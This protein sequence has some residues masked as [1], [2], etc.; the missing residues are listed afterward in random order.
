MNNKALYAFDKRQ[1][2][3]DLNLNYLIAIISKTITICFASHLK[4]FLSSEILIIY[5]GKET[6]Q[7]KHKA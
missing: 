1:R 7:E 3:F 6:N 4:G 5:K 2:L